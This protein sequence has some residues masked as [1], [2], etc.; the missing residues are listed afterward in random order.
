[1]RI[2]II[3]ADDQACGHLRLIWPAMALHH[4]GH[5]VT[6]HEPGPVSALPIK[7]ST[8]GTTMSVELVER[9]PYDVIVI[10]RTTAWQWAPLIHVLHTAGIRVVLDIDDDLSA[11][12][13]AHPAHRI[14]SPV[15]D[16]TDNHRHLAAAAALVDV[17]TVTTPA[18]AERYGGHG[19]VQI[20]P[21]CLPAASLLTPRDRPWPE[22]PAIGWPGSV[23]THPGDLDV[24]RGAV[25]R[26]VAKG[27]AAFRVIGDLDGVQ[28][29]LALREPPEH[30]PAV[31]LVRYVATLAEQLD[32]GI[33]PLVDSPFNQAKSWL[34]PLEFSA[35]G[36]PWVASPTEPYRA[37]H[38]EGCGL[39]ARKPREWEAHLRRLL[40]SAGLR[41]DLVGRGREVAGRWTIEANAWRWEQAWL[42][43]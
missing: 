39:L 12:S 24:T 22:R 8:V 23:R 36:I 19:R 27:E 37:L 26:V 17:V 29:A 10:Q 21:N 20:I 30:V 9:P 16:P 14:Y 33:A 2:G 34:K 6:L 40:A 32:I 7:V 43:E 28:S 5:D 38:A 31:P 25:A 3:P 42:G 35:A 41:D 18:L 13:H 4:L 15:A 1:M 11:L